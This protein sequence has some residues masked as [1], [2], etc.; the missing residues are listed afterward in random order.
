MRIKINPLKP[1]GNYTGYPVTV[2]V[3]QDLIS[4]II[5][6]QKCHMKEEHQGH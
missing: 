5:P 2:S 4:D 1:S 6:S 3:L